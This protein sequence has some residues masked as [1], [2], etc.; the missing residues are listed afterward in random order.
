VAVPKRKYRHLKSKAKDVK[1]EPIK[2]RILFKD[3]ALVSQ[4]ALDT[5]PDIPSFTIFVDEG[6]ICA[7]AQI[8]YEDL[9][10][11][12]RWKKLITAELIVNKVRFFDPYEAELLIEA[13]WY[14]RELSELDDRKEG[15]HYFRDLVIQYYESNYEEDE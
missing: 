2:A 15:G 3:Y 6:T 1:F 4:Q 13:I 7:R 14:A 12:I 5:Y 11:F 9:R 8:T 10:Y